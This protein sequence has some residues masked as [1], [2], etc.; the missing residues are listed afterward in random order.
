MPGP[1]PKDPSTRRRRNP[2]PGFKQL[3]AEGRSGEVPAWPLVEHPE[4]S[5]R[6][7]EQ[8]KWEEMW[9]LPQAVE[10]ERI[11]C[12]DDVALYVRIWV[13]ATLPSAAKTQRDQLL[14]L[15]AK[16]GVSPKAMQ[17]LRWETTDEPKAPEQTPALRSVEPR[18]YAPTPGP[19]AG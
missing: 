17:Q 18:V 9:T 5:I 8:R 10:W 19:K 14:Q 2:T 7:I 6:A 16:I 3:P 11:R 15:D 13:E 1:P 4:P 12:Y